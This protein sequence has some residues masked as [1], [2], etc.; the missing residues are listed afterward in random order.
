MIIV[1]SYYCKEYIAY[2]SPT[3]EDMYNSFCNNA[4]CSNNATKHL[5]MNVNNKVM[6]QL[7]SYLSMSFCM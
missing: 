1:A 3:D 6:I 7:S 5:S 4:L 2:A